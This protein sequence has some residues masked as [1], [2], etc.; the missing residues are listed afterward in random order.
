MENSHVNPNESILIHKDLNSKKSIA[1]H[2]I[3]FQLTDESYEQPSI[4]LEIAK[5]K[6][7]IAIDDFIALP[8]GQFIEI[9]IPRSINDYTII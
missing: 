9:S 5:I 7:N 2:Y 6:H 4:D 1:S 8:I 3:T